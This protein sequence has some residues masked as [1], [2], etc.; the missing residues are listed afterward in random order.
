M[1]KMTVFIYSQKDDQLFFYSSEK[2]ETHPHIYSMQRRNLS[3]RQCDRLANELAKLL[4]D[5]GEKHVYLCDFLNRRHP[6]AE[7][8][9]DELWV[10]KDTTGLYYETWLE[11]YY[12]TNLYQLYSEWVET[13]QNKWEKIV[14][15]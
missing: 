8:L 1:M 15:Y 9:L 5:L 11:N 13:M 12:A 4:E 3:K 7:E 2:V 14:I 6:D 10:D